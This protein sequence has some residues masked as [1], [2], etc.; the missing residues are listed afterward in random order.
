MLDCACFTGYL[1]H[2]PHCRISHNSGN[3][4]AKR[5][6]KKKLS[7][8]E[9]SFVEYMALD[10]SNYTEAARKAGYSGNWLS[11]IASQLMKKPHIV[12]RI[13]QEKA[14]ANSK[15]RAIVGDVYNELKEQAFEVLNELREIIF[16]KDNPEA[17]RL[18]AVMDWLDR[19]G[20]KPT[21]RI[22]IESPH[23][24]LADVSSKDIFR[25]IYLISGHKYD[26]EITTLIPGRK[27]REMMTPAEAEAAYKAK[28]MEKEAKKIAK[29]V[30]AMQQAIKDKEDGH[31]ERIGGDR[32]SRQ[33]ADGGFPQ[34]EAGG[35]Q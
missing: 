34:G 18:K 13:E 8:K 24:D 1:W 23:K 20:Y 12:E 9:R 27:N 15:E 32:D 4:M 16:T 22:E 30:A 7:H 31:F 29:Q 26:N 3:T 28:E 11:R 2:N 10:D 19:A 21:D 5:I 14:I 6:K 25:E 17:V 33:G 35:D